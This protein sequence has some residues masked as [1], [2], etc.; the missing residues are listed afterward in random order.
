MPLRRVTVLLLVFTT[1]LTSCSRVDPLSVTDSPDH[2]AVLIDALAGNE[3]LLCILPDAT[4]PCAE[5]SSQAVISGAG[6]PADI[7]ARWTGSHNV[8]VTVTI[9]TL[10]KSET[11]ALGGRVQIAYR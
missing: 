5:E 3:R 8:S 11:T 2:T 1:S 6:G 10:T 9:G 7:D 4:K